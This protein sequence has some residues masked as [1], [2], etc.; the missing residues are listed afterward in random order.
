MYCLLNNTVA[1]AVVSRL[2]PFPPTNAHQLRRGDPKRHRVEI[3]F[4]PGCNTNP[5]DVEARRAAE[6]QPVGL[7][8]PP[9]AAMRVGSG[10]SS[11][12]GGGA[13]GGAG[14]GAG[15]ASAGGAGSSTHGRVSPACSDAS[16][17]TA[18]SGGDAK[19]A[20]TSMASSIAS[21]VASSTTAPDA[22]LRG[23][24]L[25]AS[26]GS[27]TTVLRPLTGPECDAPQPEVLGNLSHVTYAQ[28]LQTLGTNFVRTA[29]PVCFVHP[30]AAATN[31]TCVHGLTGNQGCC[32]RTAVVGL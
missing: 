30:A 27:T 20:P 2:P 32:G 24:T 4:S 10:A 5:F 19:A 23:R 16:E 22:S 14:A 1:L 17:A 9:R 26:S 29:P 25:S 28:P 12:P 21:S 8:S 13:G 3:M 18:A 31:A 15:A 11:G 7:E 6:V